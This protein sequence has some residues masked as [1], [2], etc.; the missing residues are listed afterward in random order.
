M[1]EAARSRWFA[2]WFGR[3][4]DKSLR[5]QFSAVWLGGRANVGPVP[6]AQSLLCIANHSS[7]WDGMGL[8]W[9]NAHA[10]DRE[11]YALMDAANLRRYR[12][13]RK[14]GAFGVD[15]HSRRDGARALRYAAGLLHVPG[16]AVWIF[17]QGREEPAHVPL[18]F[19]GGA[20]RLARLVPEAAVVPVGFRYVFGRHPR[21]AM[22]ISVGAPL[23]PAA[24]TD[25]DAQQ[26]AVAER[27]AGIDDH[28]V[29]GRGDFELVL[30]R[31]A[32]PPERA[33][34]W[35]DRLVGWTLPPPTSG[36]Q[37]AVATQPQL[38]SAPLRLPSAE[39]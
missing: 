18:R 9:L 28:L 23:P 19:R 32:P 1:I 35:L 3:S 13:F 14:V 7:W 12:F 16:R 8:L 30:G 10:L 27:L 20:A 31:H 4:V 5:R 25:V 22:Y 33:A 15:M 17:P 36:E 39:R 34:R 37:P 26:R 21:P 6:A 24:R 11:G 38:P 2:R 29:T